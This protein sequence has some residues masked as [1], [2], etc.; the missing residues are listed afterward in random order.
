M[1]FHIVF[2]KI[3]YFLWDPEVILW[4]ELQVA[5]TEVEAP[6]TFLFIS[7]TSTMA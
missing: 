1:L 7:I 6:L 3:V 5:R 4:D 2:T